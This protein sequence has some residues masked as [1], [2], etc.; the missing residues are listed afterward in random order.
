MPLLDYVHTDDW[1][2]SMHI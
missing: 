2:I 1:L